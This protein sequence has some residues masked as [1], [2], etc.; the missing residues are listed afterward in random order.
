MSLIV[1]GRMLSVVAPTPQNSTDV[2]RDKPLT[3][4]VASYSSANDCK[5]CG[6]S[7]GN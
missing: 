6:I 4:V 3:R 1:I 5:M 7:Y 2:A